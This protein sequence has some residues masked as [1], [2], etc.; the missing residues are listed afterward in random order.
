VKNRCWCWGALGKLRKENITFVMYLSG[1][2]SFRPYGTVPLP[3]EGFPWNLVHEDVSKICWGKQVGLK[4]DK[5]NW[6]FT[7]RRTC[8]YDDVS[9]NS[10]NEKLLRQKSLRKSK[11]QISCPIYFSG[12]ACFFYEIMWKNMVQ[13]DRPQIKIQYCA[14][15]WHDGQLRLQ[16]HPEYVIHIA[17]LR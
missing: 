11:T 13:P 17:I 12:T 7:W 10:Q 6:Y 8:V 5:N 15:T 9:L 4:P 1:R 3:L 2:P 14:C 16:T